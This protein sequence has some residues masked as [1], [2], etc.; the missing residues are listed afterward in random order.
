MAENTVEH[1]T[2]EEAPAEVRDGLVRA[3]EARRRR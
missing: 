1:G 3:E 2:V